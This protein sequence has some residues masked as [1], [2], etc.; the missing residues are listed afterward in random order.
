MKYLVILLTLLISSIAAAE[1][2][3]IIANYTIARDSYFY[4]KL[5]KEGGE[6]LY[7]GIPFSDRKGLNVEHV[8]P[9]SWM[10][11]TAGCLGKSRKQCRKTSKKFNQMEADLH[12]LWPALAN[13]N[14]ARSNKLLGI[15]VGEERKFGTCDFE[16][17]SDMA[18]PR[19][20]VR[21]E[22]ARS[23][24]YMNKT[25]NASIP[26]NMEKL[27]VLWHCS[28]LPSSFE[29]YRN[30]KIEELQGTRNI[31]IDKPQLINCKK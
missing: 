1:G 4:K 28:D 13:I 7:C 23:I 18:E 31:F 17:T 10:K 21:G 11:E 5:Y 22:I 24:F 15:I 8:Y 16:V 29:K 12:N 19:D 26:K 14:Q 25:Y 30:N 2:Q 6:T 3:N 27:L 9:A 20:Q